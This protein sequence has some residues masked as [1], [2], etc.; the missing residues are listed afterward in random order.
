MQQ[1]VLME[2]I[3]YDISY[4]KL[5]LF[6]SYCTEDHS[7]WLIQSKNNQHDSK[8]S[9]IKNVGHDFNKS[10]KI[11]QNFVQKKQYQF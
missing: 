6:I 5:C 9:H 8:N 1:Y 3:N 11:S 2:E 7:V 4:D 10:R